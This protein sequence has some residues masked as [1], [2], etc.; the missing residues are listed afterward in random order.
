M[1]AQAGTITTFSG[2]RTGH[3]DFPHPALGQ[4]FTPSPTARRAQAGTGA[5]ARNDGAP[6]G[7]PFPNS[8]V[9][10]TSFLTAAATF[11]A[12]S[13]HSFGDQPVGFQTSYTFSNG[14][15]T[16]MLDVPI[17]LGPGV[18]GISNLNIGPSSLNGFSIGGSTKIGSVFPKGPPHST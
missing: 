14:D 12:V 15:G 8:S 7:G 1:P 2:H 13:T 17:N 3:E 16:F 9:A 5:R 10:Q 4:D 6:I 11:G 18:T